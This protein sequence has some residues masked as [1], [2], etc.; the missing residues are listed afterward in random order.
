MPRRLTL[1]GFLVVGLLA[2][3]SAAEAK[4]KAAVLGIEARGEQDTQLVAAGKLMTEMLRAEVA[5]P[6]SP[7][8][9]SR[10]GDEDFLTVKV[11][12]DCVTAKY[13][14]M[15]RITKDVLGAK[16]AIYGTVE[17]DSRG[18]VFKLLLLNA[19]TAQPE[20]QLTEVV[21]LNEGGNPEKAGQWASAF[22][23]KLLGRSQ[24]GKLV[25]RSSEPAGTVFIDG[26]NVGSLADG[27]VVVPAVSPGEHT[28]S[29]EANGQTAQA[30]VEIIA[31]E[32]S[33]VELT[34]ADV[35]QT[36]PPDERGKTG[37]KV[38]F[39]S[40]AVVSA[41]LWGYTAFEANRLGLFCGKDCG[42]YH[43]DASRAAAETMFNP[44]G[45]DICEAADKPGEVDK[46]CKAGESALTRST[47]TFIGAIVSTLATG[48]FGYQ[49]FIADNGVSRERN[50]LSS[51]RRKE[52][53]IKI[54]PG[55]PGD[56]G[57]G[58]EITF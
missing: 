3:S 39:Y 29:V 56:I 58:L 51:R 46:A 26:K 40:G 49:A 34:I 6:K 54:L 48:V 45:N 22:Y 31:G 19:Q 55:G 17:K 24:D 4:P 8:D 12:H 25:V 2:W 27:T 23:G 47:V 30:T 41:A 21:P 15:S 43:E 9:L 52:P 13:S 1:C 20:G 38:A 11:M 10:N 57:A 7:Y 18:Y 14:C 16:Y 32:T 42:K 5:K 53:R 37:W 35:T 28:V 36:D 50:D 44:A 33:E